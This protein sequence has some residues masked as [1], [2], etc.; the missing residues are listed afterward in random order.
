M[1]ILKFTLPAIA[2]LLGALLVNSPAVAKVSKV[3]EAQQILMKLGY[4]PGSEDGK[5]GKKTRKA[6]NVFQKSFGFIETKK[7]SGGMLDVL[8]TVNDGGEKST[9]P[10][11]DRIGNTVF[12]STGERLYFDPKGEKVIQLKNGKKI[13][14]RWRIMKNGLHCETTYNKKEFCEG[15]DPLYYVIFKVKNEQRWYQLNGWKVWTMTM[16]EGKH[17]K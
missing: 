7:F 15:V 4:D 17:L 2:L 8:R 3:K 16:K 13:S 12:V 6:L 11:S 14:R 10:I 5:W 9:A 1:K